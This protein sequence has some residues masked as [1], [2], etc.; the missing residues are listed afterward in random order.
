M[1][2]GWR[3]LEIAD[4]TCNVGQLLASPRYRLEPP[5]L[6]FGFRL[7]AIRDVHDPEFCRLGLPRD[8]VQALHRPQLD[9]IVLEG[10]LWRLKR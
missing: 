1:L 4:A 10:A 3:N 8:R 2:T 9:L 7:F 6:R 5:G